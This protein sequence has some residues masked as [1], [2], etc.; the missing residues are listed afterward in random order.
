MR[1]EL[2]PTGRVPRAD[3]EGGGVALASAPRSVLIPHCVFPKGKASVIRRVGLWAFSLLRPAFCIAKLG[4][5]WP[6]WG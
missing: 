6:M 5:K 3:R 4:Q 2:R 1:K